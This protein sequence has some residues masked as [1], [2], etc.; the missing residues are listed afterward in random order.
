MA[1]PLS[2]PLLVVRR[3]E[4]VALI[5]TASGTTDVVPVALTVM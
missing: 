1:A 5:R 3:T 4:T 2:A